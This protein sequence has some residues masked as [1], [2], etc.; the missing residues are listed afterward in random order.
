MK[1]LSIGFFEFKKLRGFV[2]NFTAEELFDLHDFLYKMEVLQKSQDFDM[3]R[4]LLMFL[5][6]ACTR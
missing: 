4:Y 5:N 2:N 6:K 1:T 3:E